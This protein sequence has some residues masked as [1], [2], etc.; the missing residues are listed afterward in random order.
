MARGDSVVTTKIIIIKK[1]TIEVSCRS[2]FV[3]GKYKQ[4][5]SNSN[6]VITY[7]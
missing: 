3:L 5:P 1:K 4:S 2:S 6:F 7:R